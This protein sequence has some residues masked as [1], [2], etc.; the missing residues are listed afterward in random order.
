MLQ[1]IV[2]SADIRVPPTK[3]GTEGFLNA[4]ENRFDINTPARSRLLDF[5]NFWSCGE[6]IGQILSSWGTRPCK[7]PFV[8]SVS[9]PV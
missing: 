5:K 8:L 7:M 3:G 9:E 6:V 2:G 4:Q 1:G